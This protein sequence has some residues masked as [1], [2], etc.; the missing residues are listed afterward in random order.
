[1]KK[2]INTTQAPAAI[3]PFS[4]AVE[5]NGTIYISGQ[6][7]VDPAT[8]AFAGDTIQ[9][10]THQS[11]KN[12]QAILKEAGLDMSNVTKTTVLMHDMGDF[13]VMNEIY[14]QYFEAPYPARAAF[15]VVRLPKDALI[16][17]EA[18]AV[19]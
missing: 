14:A 4:Q 7:P 12:I 2:E 6:L 16:E 3:G 19:R 10:Q 9:E 15:Q 13:Q 17:I 18:V 1:M 8:G 11:L 5:A